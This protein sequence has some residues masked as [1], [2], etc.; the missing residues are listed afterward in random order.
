M[1]V[2]G[3]GIALITKV[4]TTVDGGARVTFEFGS[5]STQLIQKLMQKYMNFDKDVIICV[6]ENEQ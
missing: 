2:I 6:T 1:E 4:N 5:D 3:Q